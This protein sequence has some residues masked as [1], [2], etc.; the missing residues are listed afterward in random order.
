[1]SL[2]KNRNN[3]FER[4]LHQQL[5]D[6]EFKPSE[7]L[8]GRIDREVNRPEFEQRIEGKIGNYQLKPYPETWEQIEAQLPPP[9]KARKRWGVLWIGTLTLVFAG[10][11]WLGNEFAQRS[12]PALNSS[13]T[14]SVNTI[15]LSGSKQTTT[16]FKHTD[17]PIL[18][19]KASSPNHTAQTEVSP[20]T[21]APPS[22]ALSKSNNN[23][24]STGKVSSNPSTSSKVWVD[25]RLAIKADTT[26]VQQEHNELTNTP[27]NLY[28]TNK[29]L[30]TDSINHVA[31]ADTQLQKKLVVDSPE[32]HPSNTL[33]QLADSAVNVPTSLKD[34]P[35]NE[36]SKLSLTV[37]A[38]A[39]YGFMTLV[40]P[41][42]NFAENI[43]LRQ[44]IESAKLDWSGGFLVDY[45]LHKKWLVSSGIHFTNFSMNMIFGTTSSTQQTT[46]E[47]GGKLVTADSVTQSGP[48]DLRIKYSWNEIPLLFTYHFNPGKRLSLEAKFGLSYAI[49]NVVDAAMVAPNNVGV[50]NL[51]AKD[52]FPGFNNLL[53]TQAYLGVTYRLNESVTVLAMPYVKYSLN[54]MIA[55]DNWVKQYPYFLGLSAG[56]RKSF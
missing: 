23:L 54:N 50:Y 51:K 44:Q 39:N 24:T 49:V 7:S 5:D 8:W 17:Q 1:M 10:T 45:A 6:L 37:L 4:K 15:K 55:R 41:N 27:T 16:Q 56:I 43:A 40:D 26:L 53:F 36:S 22:N 29:T 46:F 28:L 20:K 34:E 31:L 30:P 19:P 52:A 47:P 13:T 21:L 42:G 18:K 14:I 48:N 12:T 32:T 35:A 3:E 2:L 38:G 11:F 25:K 9:P 33:T